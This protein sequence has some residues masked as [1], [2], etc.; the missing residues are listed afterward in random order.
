MRIL[1][2]VSKSAPSVIPV[3]RRD[4]KTNQTKTMT[5]TK[6]NRKLSHRTS[7][8][9]LTDYALSCGYIETIEDV[10]SKSTLW[11]EH[12][13]YHIRLVSKRSGVATNWES[14][15]KLTDARGR[16]REWSK[17]MI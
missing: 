4:A 2:T 1:F 12:G 9:L 14:Y 16:M 17:T 11:K 15:D 7:S 8:G 10:A 3:A 6:R 5:T 13:M